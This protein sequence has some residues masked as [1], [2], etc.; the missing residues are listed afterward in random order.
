MVG[1]GAILVLWLHFYHTDV[2]L[3]IFGVSVNEDCAVESGQ[4]LGQLGHELKIQP[5]RERITDRDCTSLN[6][7]VLKG[8]T[9]MAGKGGKRHPGSAVVTPVGVTVT[10]N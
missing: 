2:L 7:L 8:L 4:F 5:Q 10:N 6:L 1:E 9:E 3:V